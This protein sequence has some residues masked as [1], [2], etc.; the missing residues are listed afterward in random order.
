MVLFD[1]PT[2][3]NKGD[4][5][6]AVGELYAFSQ[7]NLTV[8]HYCATTEAHCYDAAQKVMH[9]YSPQELVITWHG[10]GNIGILYPGHDNLRMHWLNTY[11]NYK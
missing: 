6:I 7:L 1:L 9:Q 5:S 11:S 4:L 10:G 8:V 3:S 2:H